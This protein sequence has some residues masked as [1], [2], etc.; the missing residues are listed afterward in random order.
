METT[1]PH[2]HGFS[3]AGQRAAYV[4][5]PAAISEA[6]TICPILNRGSSAPHSPALTIASGLS[7]L[8][9]IS[10]ASP[11]SRGPG[12][13]AIRIHRSPSTCVMRANSTGQFRRAVPGN[14]RIS[15]LN[16]C[17]SAATKMTVRGTSATV[18]NR[19]S[20]TSRRPSPARPRRER[21]RTPTRGRPWRAIPT[22]FF[23]PF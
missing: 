15:P 8:H 19:L 9:A 18:R 1:T 2:S 3:T 23:A 20:G 5:S 21:A 10:T 7:S 22:L 11:A 14:R 17:A 16:S 12:P 13:L 4:S 6:T